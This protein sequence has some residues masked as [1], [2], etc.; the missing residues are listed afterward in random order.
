[1]SSSALIA[2]YMNNAE[3]LVGNNIALS[4]IRILGW[5][6]LRTILVPL[7]ATCK[8]LFD[9]TF[10]LIDF[11]SSETVNR[12]V[13]AFKPVF[14]GLMSISLFALG[15]MLIFNHE[16]KP[17]FINNI[18]LAILCVTCST[19]VFQQMNTL[20]LEIK[21]GIDSISIVNEGSN[22]SA[23]GIYDTVSN[24]LID[25]YQV[26]QEVGLSNIN[27]SENVNVVHPNL[28]KEAFHMIDYN[29]LLDPD[30][31]M[32]SWR[33]NAAEDILEQKVILDGTQKPM[34]TEIYNGVLWTSAGNNF[35]YR[36][37]LQAIPVTL[38]LVSLIVLY[39]ALS[40]KCFRLIFEL[41]F[42][43][44]MA[45]L[46]SAE[47]SGGKRLV[48]ILLF[49]RDTYIALLLT[50]CSE[51]MYYIF[52]ALLSESGLNALM[53]AFLTACLAF[54]VIDGPNI[55]EKVLGIDIGLSSAWGHIFAMARL[56]KWGTN[57]AGMPLRALFR[58]Y[59]SHRQAKRTGRAVQDAMRQNQPGFMENGGAP[60]GE[61]STGEQSNTARQNGSNAAGQSRT[62]EKPGT[63]QT[64]EEGG[65]G[66]SSGN[67][68]TG[69]YSAGATSNRPDFMESE[70]NNA[71]SFMKNEENDRTDT[72]F[73]DGRKEKDPQ[74][75]MENVKSE[76]HDETAFMENG[77]EHFMESESTRD[78]DRT[79]FEDSDRKS[80]A[81]AS[82]AMN[83]QNGKPV[84]TGNRIIDKIHQE[85]EGPGFMQG[86]QEHQQESSLRQKPTQYG[87][88]ILNRNPADAA[89]H[90]A[91]GQNKNAAGREARD[92][93]FADR[94]RIF[95]EKKEE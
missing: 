84:Q 17:K 21:G 64:A 7:A 44:L 77:S 54:I 9:N 92:S 52:S 57:V 72:A 88:R 1:M 80:D 81:N 30:E 53:Q 4:A 26:D 8:S 12:F 76:R 51:K 79:S 20:V 35:Y 68:Y 25:L 19:L 24:N 36:Y 62:S 50:V 60:Q 48:K 74:Q 49:I 71:E 61:G 28:T 94:S 95:H 33:D 18:C 86:S 5:W 40:Y 87:G 55:A 32:Y 38:Q 58:E 69:G 14:I 23:D 2:F 16:K 43:R 59:Q 37:S 78:T 75:F 11:T 70:N 10:A 27:Y 41:A 15:I 93:N 89:E 6:I 56:G 63:S 47:L 42:G 3:I 29:E 34:I 82:A 67:T 91:G 85:N 46:F 39:L 90:K 45:Y 31:K 83:E 73:M 13:D 22:G 65:A 66:F